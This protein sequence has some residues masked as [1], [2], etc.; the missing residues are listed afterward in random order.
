[1]GCFY[2]LVFRISCRGGEMN[3]VELKEWLKEKDIAIDIYGCGCCFSPMV[4]IQHKGETVFESESE[5]IY[6]I[7]ENTEK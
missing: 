4:T 6:M 5:S 7:N 1:M 2:R 3:I